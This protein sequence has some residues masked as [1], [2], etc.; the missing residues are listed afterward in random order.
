VMPSTP[1]GRSRSRPST[2]QCR[3]CRG[4]QITMNWE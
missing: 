4:G 3:G 1:S 2:W